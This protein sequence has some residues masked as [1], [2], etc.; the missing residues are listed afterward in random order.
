[1]WYGVTGL[2][3][4]GGKNRPPAKASLLVIDFYAFLHVVRCFKITRIGEEKFRKKQ[5][6]KN[7]EPRIILDVSKAKAILDKNHD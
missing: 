6:D 1:M 3:C 5:N 4:D 7:Y 2:W